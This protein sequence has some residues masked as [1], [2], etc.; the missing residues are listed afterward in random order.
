MFM[1]ID[2]Y[3]GKCLFSAC[4]LSLTLSF[5]DESGRTALHYVALYG[6]EYCLEP[7]L[8]LKNTN[9][10]VMTRDNRGHTVFHC[11]ALSGSSD[12][13]SLLVQQ[14]ASFTTLTI[15]ECLL[16]LDNRGQSPLQIAASCG[17]VDMVAQ[18]ITLCPKALNH[19]DKAG[20]TP[21]SHAAAV[22]R[23]KVRDDFFLITF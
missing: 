20:L 22:G 13:I 5:S 3:L 10:N 19:H 8:E 2:C 15:L 7:L 23:V 1:L 14:R 11:A 21:M 17:H 9:V 12:I 18:L 6:H 4:P 16:E